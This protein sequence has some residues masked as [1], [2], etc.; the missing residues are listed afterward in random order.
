MNTGASAAI[1]R[2]LPGVQ[3]SACCGPG[4]SFHLFSTCNTSMKHCQVPLSLSSFFLLFRQLSGSSGLVCSFASSSFCCCFG[5]FFGLP[6]FR[7]GFFEGGL[8]CLMRHAPEDAAVTS[9]ARRTWWT[10][11]G[12]REYRARHFPPPAQGLAPGFPQWQHHPPSPS[13]EPPLQCSCPGQSRGGQ[14]HQKTFQKGATATQCSWKKQKLAQRVQGLKIHHLLFARGIVACSPFSALVPSSKARPRTG[15]PNREKGDFAGM[16][17]QAKMASKK[18][19]LMWAFIA[20]ERGTYFLL[21]RL[22]LWVQIPTTYH[23]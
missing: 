21:A 13:S 22:F 10:A 1:R 2:R 11:T 23:P 19:P 20:S 4:C 18:C 9:P 6:F 15:K 12:W 5:L 7:S 14:L 3:L 8:F 16:A 17:P